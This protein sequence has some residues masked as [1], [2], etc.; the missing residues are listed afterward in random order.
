MPPKNKAQTP[1]KLIDEQEVIQELESL[2]TEQNRK[3]YKRH[4]SGE[5]V[6]GVSYANLY[7]LQKK[8]K[9]NTDLAEKLW[10]SGIQDARILATM[11]ADAEKIT[12]KTIDRWLKQLG[13]RGLSDAVAGVI[14]QTAYAQKKA[15]SLILEENEWRCN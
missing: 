5:K 13:N 15:E 9:K 3:T 2:G 12:E 4:G 8:F 10:E 14:A 6:F 1:N 11:I 7:K